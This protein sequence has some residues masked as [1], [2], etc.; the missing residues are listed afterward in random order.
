MP[1]R[2]DVDS[3]P[4]KLMSELKSIERLE[5]L[6]RDLGLKATDDELLD[7]LGG[8]AALSKLTTREELHRDFLMKML[9]RAARK[10]V[11]R[12]EM[13]RKDFEEFTGQPF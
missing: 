4:E 5:Q 10:N 7:V 2:R 9:L 6:R 11:Q 3:D 12:G 8:R 1:Q 13:T